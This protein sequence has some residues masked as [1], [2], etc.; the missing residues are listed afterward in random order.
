MNGVLVLAH[1]RL[2]HIAMRAGI[3]INQERKIL[4]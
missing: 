3:T 4:C 2:A 1:A